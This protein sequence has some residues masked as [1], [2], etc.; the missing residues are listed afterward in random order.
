MTL[1]DRTTKVTR[2][3]VWRDHITGQQYEA[4]VPR[5]GRDENLGYYP[6][7]RVIER[8]LDSAPGDLA[9]VIV[10]SAGYGDHAVITGTRT[11]RGDFIPAR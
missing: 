7:T 8:H 6:E 1:I 2:I 11:S 5:Y 4:K 9:P 3:D 10:A